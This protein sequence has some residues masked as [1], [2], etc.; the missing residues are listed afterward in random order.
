MPQLQTHSNQTTVAAAVQSLIHT[1]LRGPRTPTAG[2]AL[3]RMQ[4]TM[5]RTFTVSMGLCCARPP[6][7]KFVV[8]LRFSLCSLKVPTLLQV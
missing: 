2:T 3:W 6:R 4:W 7:H 5:Q 1:T 8:W